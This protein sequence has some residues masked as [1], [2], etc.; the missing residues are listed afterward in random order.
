MN[1]EIKIKIDPDFQSL[2]KS[3]SKEE[4][5]QLEKSILTEGLRDSL[6]LWKGKDILLDGHHRLKICREHNIEIAESKKMRIELANR[7]KAK[8]WIVQ[9]QFARR[10]L[11]KLERCRLA[12]KIETQIKAL[13][14][15][16][17]RTHTKQGYLKSNKADAVDTLKELSKIAGVGRDFLYKYRKVFKESDEII[18]SL[19]IDEHL[20][21]Y[22]GM[23][24]IKVKDYEE[25]MDKTCY[26]L[27]RKISPLVLKRWIE[28]GE[29]VMRIGVGGWL[30][31]C[32]LGISWKTL[33][34]C[35]KCKYHRGQKGKKLYENG[36]VEDSGWIDCAAYDDPE[37][38]SSYSPG[39][40]MFIKEYIKILKKNNEIEEGARN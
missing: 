38:E 36:T 35:K 15:E 7:D 9:N 18:Q 39:M 33:G 37:I 23:E 19:I 14:K 11:N 31:F 8:L 12:L 16:K 40:K 20:N 24:L 5:M 1:K 30:D 17:L 25:R 13:A 4:F 22:H 26:C 34:A 32:P 2:I 27:T 3:L 6:V 21:I 29:I 28:K 10:N